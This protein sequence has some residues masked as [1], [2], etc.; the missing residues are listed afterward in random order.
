MALNTVSVMLLHFW[1]KIRVADRISEHALTG[2]ATYQQASCKRAGSKIAKGE[3]RIGTNTIF[4]RDEE[5]RW[6]MAW[7]HW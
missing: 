5:V 6:Y 3:L 7:R 2:M 1:R 4:D